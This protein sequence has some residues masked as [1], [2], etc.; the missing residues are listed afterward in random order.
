MR[1]P[2][3]FRPTPLLAAAMLVVGTGV[4]IS[5]V[6]VDDIALEIGF[7]DNW[8]NT[9]RRGRSL[10]AEDFD[11][12]GWV[13]FFV[14]NPGN[15]S[16]IYR[17]LGPDAD[18]VIQFE[19]AQILLN[20]ALAS[21]ASAAD[22][23]NDNDLDIFVGCGGLEGS[24]LDF[25]FRN[26]STQG[27]IQF[28]S[29]GHIAGILGPAPTGTP[30][31][32]ATS[33]STWGDYD[34]DGD[35]DLFVSSRD[36]DPATINYK[37]VLWLNN[38]NGTFTDYTVTA[39]LDYWDSE[40]GP[41]G[42]FDWGYFQNSSWIDADND[43][44]LDLF[45]NNAWGPNVF[46]KNRLVETGVARFEKATQAFAMPGED[47]RY[48]IFSFV[49]AV[50]DFNND[51]W[52]DIVLLNYT[53]EPPGGPYPT[54]ENALWI[55]Q[56]GRFYNAAETAGIDYGSGGVPQ[57]VMGCQ[58]ADLNADGIE[59][60]FLGRGQP[61]GGDPDGLFLSTGTSGGVPLFSDESNL[62]AF[63]PEHGIDPSQAPF[64]PVPPFPYRTHGTVGVDIDRDGKLEL[65]IINGAMA[66]WPA[67]VSEPNQMF[68]FSGNGVGNTF[69][70][71]LVGNGVTDSRDGIGARAY[72]ETSAGRV[73]RTVQGGS[74]FSAH[75]ERAL[76]FGLGNQSTVSR[77][78]IL[79]PSGCIQIIDA[80]AGGSP[81]PVQIDQTCWTCAAAPTPVVGWMNPENYG[82]G[83]CAV[84]A[85]CDDGVFCNGAESCE[86]A[87]GVC[88]AGT[89]PMC[90]DGNPCTV[91][92]CDGAA[93][94]CRN[95][96]P[97][98]P[99]EVD[100]LNLFLTAPGSTA[101]TLVWNPE[102]GADT[103]N[104]YR[105][106]NP[107]LSDLVCWN[108]AVPATSCPE[109]DLL[110][111]GDRFFYLVTAVNCG[112]ESTLGPDPAGGE[113]LNLLPCQ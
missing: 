60:L 84:D 34:R 37:S 55:N 63:A 45:L 41:G 101:S 107:N 112:G 23:D 77:L 38:G 100:Q 85:D 67:V 103:Y 52:Q 9:Y 53:L 87:T 31:P 90:D 66:V 110:T 93:D 61:A 21:V 4:A 56:A 8:S 3:K 30:L 18:G 78:S 42:I 51:G 108:P 47:M 83:P 72:V 102:A 39:G 44:D 71:L 69:R 62:I 33:G 105:A 92:A 80:P 99:G 24:C 10:V 97:A 68:K 15:E 88:L 96:P 27:N 25:L 111:P 64:P 91:D 29:V 36:I 11:G 28:T 95:D 74:C 16:F 50:S 14:G 65:G 43:G 19:V 113:R 20:G 1:A 40:P 32:T 35:T 17:N 104:V 13:D 76:T 5:K 109:N 89:V 12:D 54:T 49:S 58:V 48:P 86:V 82:C 94:A 2:G 57:M 7:Q 75:N 73:Y 98:P 79:W 22:Y 46:W 81:L 59:D 70:A 26:D 6:F 106:A